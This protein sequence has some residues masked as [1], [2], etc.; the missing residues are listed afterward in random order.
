[1]DE[2]I[3]FYIYKY[4]LMYQISQK[5]FT[6]VD[7]CL[8]S[9]VQVNTKFN[10][11]CLCILG[12][13]KQNVQDSVMCMER[14]SSYLQHHLLKVVHLCAPYTNYVFVHE[15]TG[16][17]RLLLHMEKVTHMRRKFP[18]AQFFYPVSTVLSASFRE[19]LK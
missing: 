14:L 1:M 16:L 6:G 2:S 4:H 10:N 5:K 9:T 18:I 13:R 8:S 3:P 19:N 15:I 17:L 11:L 12:V 7:D